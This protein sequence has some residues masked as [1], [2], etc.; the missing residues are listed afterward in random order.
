LCG[1]DVLIFSDKR[2][3]LS[4]NIDVKLAWSRW[5]RKAIG[6]SVAQINGAARYLREH[7]GQ[8]FLD[9][10]CKERF[11]LAFPPAEHRRVHLIAVALGASEACAEY[12]KDAPGY[13][14]IDPNLKGEGHTNTGAEGFQPFA[15][16]DVQPDGGFVHVFN[17]PALELLASELDTVTDFTR[18]L[19]RRERIIRSGCDR[20]R[21]SGS[22]GPHVPS[23]DKL[24]GGDTF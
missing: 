24:F 10:A 13:F 15:I 17:E 19:T 16:G 4:S 7:P 22:A 23:E 14:A 18:Y 12:R 2:I 1:D 8:L 9:A 21:D 20:E 6:K 11:P 3:Q 5:Y